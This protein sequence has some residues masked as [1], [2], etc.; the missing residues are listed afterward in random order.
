MTIISVFRH[1]VTVINMIVDAVEI[2]KPNS[3]VSHI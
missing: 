3:A 1:L 2:K